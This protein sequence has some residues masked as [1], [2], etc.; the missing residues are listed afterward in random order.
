MMSITF[1][2]D[3]QITF[4]LHEMNNCWCAVKITVSL[5]IANPMVLRV[6]WSRFIYNSRGLLQPSLF[7]RSVCAGDICLNRPHGWR[8]NQLMKTSQSN[9]HE[10]RGV[11]TGAIC[12]NRPHGCQGYQLVVPCS[13]VW[14]SICSFDHVDMIEFK[15]YFKCTINMCCIKIRKK[16]SCKDFTQMSFMQTG[17]TGVDAFNSSY[18]A[19]VY[20]PLFV[21]LFIMKWW[22]YAEDRLCNHY[23]I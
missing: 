21:R 8:G 11:Y 2:R 10:C 22:V 18:H 1:T 20:D 4:T 17:R 12:Q 9:R 15:Q 19:L 23:S 7:S 6:S 14:P 13:H 3:K 16:I 5:P